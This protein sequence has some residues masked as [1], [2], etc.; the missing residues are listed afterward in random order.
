MNTLIGARNALLRF[1]YVHLL[2]PVFFRFDPEVVHDRMISF[3]RRLGRFSFTRALGK[4]FFAFEDPIL[5]QHICSLR[6]KNPI[7]LAGGFDKNARAID[8]LPSVGFGFIE[9]GS[10]TARPCEGNAG[11][12]LWRMP[13]SKSLVVNYGLKN[14][15]VD[16]IK[17]R[18]NQRIKKRIFP[19][20]IPLGTNLAFTNDD[21]VHTVESAIAD[22]EY[23]FRTLAETGDYF[24]VN[25]SCPNRTDDRM[26][27]D[28]AAFGK[29]LSRLFAI[30]TRKP[31][32]IKISPDMTAEIIGNIVAVAKRYPV[33]GFIVSN[34][35]KDR[36]NVHIHESNI[37]EKGGMSGKVVDELSDVAIKEVYR[38]TQGAYPIIASGGV[39]SAADAFRKISLGASLIQM[40]TGLVYEG[41]QVVSEI[42]RGLAEL[43]RQKGFKNIQEAVGWIK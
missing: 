27:W 26:F 39:F 17:K 22:Y 7:G 20:T 33:S 43:L 10:I 16:E 36:N 31:V 32:F 38:L 9:V 6:F 29:M 41:P 12:H 30:P 42:N 1:G 19:N 34:L 13:Q 11:R 28:E 8:F 18:I 23:S 3:G 24:T 4:V 40:I 15:G 37:P 14:D 21:S 2:K 25:I 5:E 35:T